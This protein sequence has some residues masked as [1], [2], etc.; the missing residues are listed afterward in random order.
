MLRNLVFAAGA[1]AIGALGGVVYGN[2]GKNASLDAQMPAGTQVLIVAPVANAA[3]ASARPE[4]DGK[5]SEAQ[6]AT[7]RLEGSATETSA[8]FRAEPAKPA[9]KPRPTPR[10]ILGIGW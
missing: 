3:Q 4:T 9:A 2:L 10:L 5:E 1:L 7:A 6:A 8:A